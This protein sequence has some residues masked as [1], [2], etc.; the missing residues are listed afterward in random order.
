MT[1]DLSPELREEETETDQIGAKGEEDLK[2][3]ASLRSLFLDL[4]IAT[5]AGEDRSRG[6]RICA[7]SKKKWRRRRK[8]KS[9]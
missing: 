2:E 9:L 8:R 7:P 6:S 3:G 1:E 4:D 5:L